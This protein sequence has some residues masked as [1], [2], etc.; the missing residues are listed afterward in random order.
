MNEL[1][2]DIVMSDCVQE[3]L[4]DAIFSI[5][6][7]LITESEY[8]TICNEVQKRLDNDSSLLLEPLQIANLVEYA[9]IAYSAMR[10]KAENKVNKHFLT[11]EQSV[12]M[13]FYKQLGQKLKTKTK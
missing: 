10:V 13:A 3:L 9:L 12:D 8:K 5:E 2:K 6:E 4:E 11:P 7:G 1:M